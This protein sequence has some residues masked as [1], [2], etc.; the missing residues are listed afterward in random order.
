MSFLKT[1]T[2]HRN[3]SEPLNA[4]LNAHTA[5]QTCSTERDQEMKKTLITSV[6]AFAILLSAGTSMAGPLRDHGQ[7]GFARDIRSSVSQARNQADGMAYTQRATKRPAD[8]AVGE[9]PTALSSAPV[10][11][12]PEVD[13]DF[14]L[15]RLGL[16]WFNLAMVNYPYPANFYANLPRSGIVAESFKNEFQNTAD[17]ARAQCS[18]TPGCPLN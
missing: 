12:Y 11:G 4:K 5:F 3:K 15:N 8:V 1:L 18:V 16:V 10:Q 14:L 2:C 17:D 6:T 7:R 13:S 9:Q